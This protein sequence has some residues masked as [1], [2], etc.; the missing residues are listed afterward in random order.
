MA[1]AAKEA[2]KAGLIGSVLCFSM[3]FM[4]NHFIVPFPDSATANSINN[5]ISGLISGFLSGFMGLFMYLKTRK[6]E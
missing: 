5:G 1:H 4:A 6:P 2:L 3:S